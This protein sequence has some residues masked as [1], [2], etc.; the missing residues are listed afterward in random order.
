MSPST[1]PSADPYAAAGVNYLDLDPFKKAAQEAALGTTNNFTLAEGGHK[2]CEYGPSRGGSAHLFETP[3]TYIATVN[4]GLGTKNLVADE[5][6]RLTDRLYYG[7]VA[8]CTV[9][10]IVN[11]MITSGA[12]PAVV[13]MHI[14]AGNSEW[15]KDGKRAQDL[16]NGWKKACDLSRCI[17]GGG[18][19]PALRGVVFPGTVALSGSA[20]GIIYPKENLIKGDICP[21]DSIVIIESSGIHANGLSLARDVAENL[22][23]G[24][25]TKLSDGRTYG[26]TL[27]DPTHIYVGLIAECLAAGIRPHYAENITGHGWRKF[28]RPNKPFTYIIETLPTQQLIFD[29]IQSQ[30]GLSDEHAYGNFNMG[31]GFALYLPDAQVD[32]VVSIAKGLD[33]RAFKAGHVAD[34]EKKVVIEPKNLVFK[35]ESLDLRN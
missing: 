10:M 26:D 33:L 17:W 21:G 27:L 16:I 7:N 1:T 29:F 34:G 35:A 11:D 9:A 3:T 19:T 8:Q 14:A 22:P 12:L 25:L 20:T 6:Y 32:K 24:Y 4:E 28:M 18:E 23:D 5:M 13:A 15:F 31:A 2:F 30:K